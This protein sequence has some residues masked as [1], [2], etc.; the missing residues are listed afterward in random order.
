L[1]QRATVQCAA[2]RLESGLFQEP[3]DVVRR[4]AEC[5]GRNA[6]PGEY[7]ADPQ[8]VPLAHGLVV[9][10]KGDPAQAGH[11]L[12]LDTGAAANTHV[13]VLPCG[14]VAGAHL[15]GGPHQAAENLAHLRHLLGRVHVGMGHRLDQGHPQ[16]VGEVNPLVPH[17][18]HLA[19]GILL[20]PQLVNADFPA[21]IRYPAVHPDD[22]RALKTGG[23]AAVEVLLAGHV[24]LVH[25]LEIQH[26][27]HLEGDVQGLLVQHERRRVVHFVGAY[28]VAIDAVDDLLLGLE[29][30]QRGAVVLAQ[31]RERRPHVPQD[32]GVVL[33]AVETGGTPAEY[34]L[35]GEQLL[36]DLQTGAQADFRVVLRRHL[37]EGFELEHLQ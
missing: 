21:L 14:T 36:V 1:T 27:G 18:G 20:Q 34:L 6:A 3:R 37:I 8:Q 16:P 23:D 35:V 13:H 29:L 4:R 19:T 28:R 33:V 32:L 25:Q 5:L 26:Q 12:D 17:V 15:S 2:Q 30:H 10:Q 31:L 9:N 22:R 7:V 24:E 11:A